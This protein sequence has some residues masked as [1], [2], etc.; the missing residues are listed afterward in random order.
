MILDVSGFDKNTNQI[1]FDLIQH[2]LLK[3]K[4]EKPVTN[5]H[6]RFHIKAPNHQ[7]NSLLFLISGFLLYSK[8]PQKGTYILWLEMV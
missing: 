6:V 3:K 7:K 5:Q 2:L 4:N 8:N 1:T